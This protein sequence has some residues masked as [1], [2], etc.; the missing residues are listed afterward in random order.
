MR[1]YEKACN[2]RLLVVYKLNYSFILSYD[3][4]KKFDMD[5]FALGIKFYVYFFSK[6]NKFVFYSFLRL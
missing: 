1:L 6:L 2:L 5:A 3:S 4:K